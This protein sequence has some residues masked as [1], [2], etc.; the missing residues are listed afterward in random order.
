MDAEVA[1]L[2]VMFLVGLAVGVFFG[3]VN[4]HNDVGEMRAEI[5][6]RGYGLYCPATGNFAFIG[7]CEEKSK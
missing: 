2:T 4:S 3:A 1:R 6:E 5:I 7:E